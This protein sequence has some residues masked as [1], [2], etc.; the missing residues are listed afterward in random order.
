MTTLNCALDACVGDMI[1]QDA[2]EGRSPRASKLAGS[3]MKG[4]PRAS[5]QVAVAGCLNVEG[6][7]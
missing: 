2:V 6:G 7:T 5:R 4:C 1:Q 3:N